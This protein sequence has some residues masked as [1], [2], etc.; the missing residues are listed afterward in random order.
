MKKILFTVLFFC[1]MSLNVNAATVSKEK[2]ENVVSSL[3]GEALSFLSSRADK[4][5][6]SAVVEK[7]FATLL[8]EYFNIDYIGKA[9]LGQYWR[10]AN[11]NDRKRYLD[12]FRENI[13]KVYSLRFKDYKEQTIKIVKSSVRGRGDV[14]VFSKILSLDNEQPPLDLNWRVR[15]QKD[16]S[17]RIIDLTVAGVSM[18][19]TQKNEYKAIIEKNG[20][21]ISALIEELRKA[22]DSN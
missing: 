12:T 17:Y 21:K 8:E 13:V 19:I 9:S 7:K 3:S 2:A 14:I 22:I 4:E 11:S 18:L 15:L 20:G 1:L 5:W 6:D 10:K 16:G